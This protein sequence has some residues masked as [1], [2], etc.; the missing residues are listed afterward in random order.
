MNFDDLIPQQP[1]IN[2]DDL[3]PQQQGMLTPPAP[4]PVQTAAARIDPAILGND[5]ATQALAKSLGRSQ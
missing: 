3:I 2:F 5:P 4:Q 1:E